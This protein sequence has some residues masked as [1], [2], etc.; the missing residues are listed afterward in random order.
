MEKSRSDEPS[1]FAHGRFE[2][3]TLSHRGSFEGT[4]ATFT[5]IL[6]DAVLSDLAPMSVISRITEKG[7]VSIMPINDRIYRV[8]MIDLERRNIP[9]DEAVTLEEF[10]SSLIRTTGSDLGLNDVNWM[11]RFGNAT[12]QAGRYRSGRLFL[13]GDSAHIHFPAGGQGMNVGL[14]EAMNLGW[15]L[16][17]AIKGW[18]PGLAIGQLSRRTFPMEYGLAPKYRGS[19]PAPGRDSSHHGTA[20]LAG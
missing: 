15:K 2:E 16:A 7:L 9:K 3:W 18:A 19:N 14:Q 1:V 8:L 10:R 17:G 6:G 12:R 11:S 13:A 20:E 5:A 4:D